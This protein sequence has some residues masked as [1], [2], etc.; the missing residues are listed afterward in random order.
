MLIMVTDDGNGLVR[1]LEEQGIPAE[2][3][4]KTTGGNDKIVTNQ[5]EIRY[6]EPTKPDEIYKIS[7]N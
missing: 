3:I 1:A 6:L 7:F 5:D 2:I 4:G